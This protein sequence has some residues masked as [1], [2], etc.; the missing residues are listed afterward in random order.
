MHTLVGPQQAVSVSVLP[1]TVKK[2]KADRLQLFGTL[3]CPVLEVSQEAPKNFRRYWLEFLLL[4]V[5]A[6]MFHSLQL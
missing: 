6:P 3:Q 4:H 2:N 1:W 5:T